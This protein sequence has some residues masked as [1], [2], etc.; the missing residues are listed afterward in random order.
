MVWTSPQAENKRSD[1]HQ[2]AGAVGSMTGSGA[3]HEVQPEDES[4]GEENSHCIPD[5]PAQPGILTRLARLVV[6]GGG[7]TNCG[8]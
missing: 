5:S 7:V 1:G 3:S 8:H 2:Q 6:V 4:A